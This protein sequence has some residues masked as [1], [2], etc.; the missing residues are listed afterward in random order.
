MKEKIKN[1]FTVILYIL[2]IFLIQILTVILYEIIYT[3]YLLIYNKSSILNLP[4]ILNNVAIENIL[5]INLIAYVIFFITIAIIYYI[6][7]KKITVDISLINT[8]KNTLLLT[9]FLGV[10]IL[11]I[12]IGFLGI[13][14]SST[15]FSN[16]WENFNSIINILTIRGLP[17]TILIIGIITPIAEELLFRG[18]VYNTLLKSFPILPTIFIQA[19]LFG[20]CHGNI[21]Q[22]IYTTFL[23]I[24]FGYLIYKTKSLYSSI[25][26]H[27][28]NNLTAIIVFNFLPKNI[29][30]ILTYVLFIILGI[31]FTL[32]F[33]II[34]NK[35]NKSR[36]KMDSIPFSNL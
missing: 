17:E 30:S 3:L 4:N 16:I 22:C 25:I 12:N 31:S 6:H 33:L 36:F 28:S 10:S 5:Y 7:G 27:I 15:F 19:F 1:I 2:F 18:L 29:N 8:N 23:G 14:N 9:F 21:I 11:C 13:L 24:V 34:L 35:N 32:L 20:I 26:A